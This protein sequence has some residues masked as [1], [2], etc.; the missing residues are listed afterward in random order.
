VLLDV[1]DDARG[2]VAQRLPRRPLEGLL[3]G[4]DGAELAAVREIVP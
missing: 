3:G 1:E 4:D 2:E